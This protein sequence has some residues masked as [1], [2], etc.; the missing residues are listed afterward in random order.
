L[1]PSLWELVRPLSEYSITVEAEFKAE[2]IDDRN[3]VGRTAK[4]KRHM[5]RIWAIREPIHSAIPT[6]EPAGAKII[7]SRIET[8][9]DQISSNFDAR[10]LIEANASLAEW[11][12]FIIENRLSGN[13]DISGDV[14]WVK[15]GLG[16]T[17]LDDTPRNREILIAAM[18]RRINENFAKLRPAKHQLNGLPQ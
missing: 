13:A 10:L 5:N 7:G 11:A 18:L 6:R 1:D 15:R 9:A 2:I 12:S 17:T 3:P 4:L 8:L 16:L 14:A